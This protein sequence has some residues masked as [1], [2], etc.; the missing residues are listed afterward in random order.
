MLQS[1]HPV[2]DSQPAVSRIRAVD[3]AAALYAAAFFAWLALRTPGTIAAEWVGVAAFVPLGLAV[4]W[5]GWRNSRLPG[6]DARERMAWRWLAAA[7]VALH[8]SGSAW[9][10]YL[11]IAGPRDWPVW[12]D[13]IE[14]LYHLL[15]VAG[16]L[17][18]PTRV[19]DR[20]NRARF[21]TDVFLV[22]AAGALVAFYF[23][24]RFWFGQLEQEPLSWA[25][26]G[27][28]LD[29]LVFT[30]AA[31]GTLQKRDAATRASVG[32]LLAA[33]MVYTGANYV[34]TLAAFKPGGSEY[35]PG[36]GVDGLWFA[37][38]ILRWAAARYWF[39][40][41]SGH[42]EPAARVEARP[43]AYDSAGTA[44]LVVAGCFILLTSQ[45]FAGEQQFLPYLALSAAAMT[46]VLM[47]RA[48][49]RVASERPALRGA[50]G[51]GGAVQVACR[52]LL[53]RR[54]RGGRRRNRRVRQRH[55]G[56]NIRRAVSAA[57]RRPPG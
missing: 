5:A 42:P 29:W 43:T 44:Y 19:F 48:V 49:D 2:M 51:A 27:P 18:F 13:H 10:L 3:I 37:A 31:V 9:D 4:A 52:S 14:V 53:R 32:L 35:R 47:A 23:G 21:V 28:G 1:S 56:E 26:L 45:V 33:A 7:A 16:I 41:R 30:I 24:L 22:A 17:A 20:A 6:L 15:V 54:A 38:W 55:R 57:H 50:G 25:V 36:D 40:R 11:R 46:S 39:Y 8:I 12:T 34:F